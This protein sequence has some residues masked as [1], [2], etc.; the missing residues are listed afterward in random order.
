LVPLVFVLLG[1]LAAYSSALWYGFSK[2]VRE[3]T[4][5]RWA[6]GLLLASPVF[7]LMALY[8]GFQGL[9]TGAEWGV[10]IFLALYMGLW[11]VCLI[12]VLI[13]ALAA[14]R[15]PGWGD[16]R[17]TLGSTDAVIFSFLNWG[18][19]GGKGDNPWVGALFF[20]FMPLFPPF[21]ALFAQLK[22]AISPPTPLYSSEGRGGR[23]GAGLYTAAR[24]KK[25]GRKRRER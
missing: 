1:L 6:W 23:R 12:P 8:I 7:T 13:W 22:A 21:T 10:L 5:T 17:Y 2:R 4:G 25:R 24:A 3:L 14:D 19:T 16:L 18:R 15:I 20:F 9:L 11:I